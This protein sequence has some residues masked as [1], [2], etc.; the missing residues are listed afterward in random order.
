MLGW[1]TRRGQDGRA[2]TVAYVVPHAAHMAAA[3]ATIHQANRERRIAQWRMAFDQN[4]RSGSEDNAAELR[5]LEQQL[6]E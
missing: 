1:L 5:W 2:Y 6:C 4:Y 3:R